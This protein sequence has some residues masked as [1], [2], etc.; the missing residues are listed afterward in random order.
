MPCPI[1]T[2]PIVEPDQYDGSSPELSPGK[3]IPVGLPKP[4]REIH[5][6]SRFCPSSF[7]AIVIAPTF[8]ERWRICATVIRS[9]GRT[10][11][12]WMTRSATRIEYGSMNDVCGVTRCSE[13]APAIVTILNTDP[14]SNASATA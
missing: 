11:A 8:D 10:S 1:G 9:V 4:K 3:S 6:C 5:S 2:L 14:G 12:S 7:V 13:S